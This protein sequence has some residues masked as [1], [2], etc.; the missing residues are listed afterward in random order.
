MKGHLVDIFQSQIGER[1][2]ILA[3]GRLESGESFALVDDRMPPL[4]YLRSSERSAAQNLL[5]KHRAK[6]QSSNW[7]TFDGERVEAWT[8]TTTAQLKTLAQ[9]LK[10]VGVRT[11]EA[12][13]DFTLRYRMERQISSQIEIE[14]DWRKSDSVDRL[15]IN[16]R[17]TTSE[18]AIDLRVLALDI[19]TDANA[20][21][22]FGFSFVSWTISGE[23]L[24]EEV[25]LR[26]QGK[27]P[28]GSTFYPTEKALLEALQSR[29]RQIDPD[30]ISG[31]NVI[32]FDLAVIARLFAKYRLPFNLG[33]SKERSYLRQS[34][35]FGRNKIVIHGR[36]VVDAMQLVRF[37]LTS[38]EDLRLGTVARELLGRGKTL[39]IEEW[40]DAPERIL[41]AFE[42]DKVAF[43][44]YV[45]EDSRLVRDILRSKQLIEL[46]LARTALTHMPL[47]RAWS[48]VAAFENLYIGEMHKRGLV[49]PS[50]GVDS[51]ERWGN[52]GGLVLNPKP[53]LH[54]EVLVFD[55]KSLYPSI[56]RTFNIDPLAHARA[57]AIRDKKQL[58]VA[59]NDATFDRAP[60]ILPAILDDFFVNRERAKKAGQSA[61][62]YAYK[63]LM[64]SFYGV[65]ATDSCRFA[66]SAIADAITGFGQ[67]LL[68]WTRDYFEARGFQVLYGDTDSLFVR[69]PNLATLSLEERLLEG[70]RLSVETNQA[71]AAYIQ[72]RY[73][74]SSRMELEFEKYYRS[75]FLPSVRQG[76][77]GRAKN[78]AGLR[79]SLQDE[80]LEITGMEA[81]R[82][83]WTPLARDLQ[84][85][86]LRL[87]FQK[88]GPE[89]MLETVKDRIRDL[90]DGKR[91]EDLVYRK[92]IRKPLA[93]YTKTTPPHIKAARLLPK[94]VRVV[95]YVIT[96]D[97]PQPLGFQTAAL[98]YS[99]Y[100][101]KQIRPIVEGLAP[102]SAFSADEACA[103][104]AEESENENEMLVLG[105]PLRTRKDR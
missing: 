95:R 39:T 17:L 100:I 38:F 35:G 67:H 41:K 43:C 84:K 34:K 86:L 20:S 94:T 98:D 99:F 24:N 60:A 87:L 9:D 73:E 56:M 105:A 92:R 79:Q 49:A 53:G 7:T 12:D 25:H 30:I 46:A 22:V 19:E 68:T 83:D 101:E 6:E 70:E 47:E 74:V 71:L 58:I 66:D 18:Q 62:S 89:R 104:A 88:A 11:Y 55:F 51:E 8:V 82:S 44:E 36:Q 28:A 90:L 48:S 13:L 4:L 61:A 52:S 65:L 5:Q 16:P 29:L 69:V 10:S 77:G 33:R 3:A 37:S 63:I 102:F 81:V 93:A 45:L 1:S 78:Y 96:E 21:E 76:E 54:E 27:A 14:G 50:W 31:W 15:Y 40:E 80:G 26:G 85:D 42:E 103:Y 72:K 75:F 64:N 59:P 91:D 32:D 97:G 23:S 57:K 2:V